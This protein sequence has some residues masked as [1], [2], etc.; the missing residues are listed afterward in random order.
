[1]S[2]KFTPDL[3][4]TSDSGFLSCSLGPV[5]TY[6]KVA[7]GPLQK[8]QTLEVCRLLETR[9][10]AQEPEEDKDPRTL[11]QPMV[12]PASGSLLDSECI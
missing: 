4:L 5:L 2:M 7:Q 3:A 11:F 1:M 12:P 8:Y 9:H 10:D 6:G